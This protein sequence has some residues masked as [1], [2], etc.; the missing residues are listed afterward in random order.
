M[1]DT[2]KDQKGL[3]TT[4]NVYEIVRQQDGSFDVFHNGDLTDRSIPE[5]WLESRLLR[6][7]ICREEYRD[8]R[9]KIDVCGRVRLVYKTGRVKLKTEGRKRFISEDGRAI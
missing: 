4:P 8:A 6:Y 2:A 3:P 5:Q 1:S 7:G 9:S